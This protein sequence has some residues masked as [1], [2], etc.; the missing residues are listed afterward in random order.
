MK[1]AL[2]YLTDIVNNIF[3]L[4]KSK[5]K[6]RLRLYDVLA[7][8]F[9]LHGS[10]C[11]TSNAND[12]SRLVTA[13]IKFIRTSLGYNQTQKNRKIFPKNAEISR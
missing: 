5:I 7:I 13:E 3:K 2:K 8:L 9:A 1:Q 4:K 12:K 10:K 6:S 11:W